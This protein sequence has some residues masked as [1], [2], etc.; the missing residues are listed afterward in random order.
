MNARYRFTVKQWEELSTNRAGTQLK[1][2]KK[3]KD[4]KIAIR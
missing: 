4:K 2:D 3:R 1:E